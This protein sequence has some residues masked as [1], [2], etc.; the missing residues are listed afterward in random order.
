[1]R[2]AVDTNVLARALVEDDTEQGRRALRCVRDNEIF[3][4]ETVLL[5]TEWLLRSHLGVTRA[6][7]NAVLSKLL[8]LRNVTFDD[9]TKIADAL[10][11][12]RQGMDFADALHLLSAQDCAELVSF[13]R[14]F[15]RRAAELALP[16]PVREP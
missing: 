5:E 8:S 6:A 7:V 11:A 13:D 3:V 12:H 10:S 9:S 1:M 15:A 2:R 16:I 4:P 14:D